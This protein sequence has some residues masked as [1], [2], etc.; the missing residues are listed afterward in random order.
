MMAASAIASAQGITVMIDGQAVNFRDAQ[1]RMMNGR[2]LV[3]LRGV[4]EQMGAYVHWTA[5]TETI[6]A[7]KGATSVRL[8]IGDRVANVNGQDV[9]LDVPARL[10]GGSTMVPLRFVSEALGAD[11]NWNEP[12][13]TVLITTNGAAANNNNDYTSWDNNNNNNRND[14]NWNN[15]NRNRNGNSNRRTSRETM[16]VA[17]PANTVIPVTLNTTLSSNQSR[18]GDT[19]TANVDTQGSNSYAGVPAGTIAEGHVVA[20]MPQNGQNPGTIQVAFDRLRMPDGR[21]AEID[22]T[23]ASMNSKDITRN[24]NGTIQAKGGNNKPLV[25][26]GYGAGAGAVIGMLTKGNILTDAAIGA[27]L[28]YLVNILQKDKNNPHDVLLNSGTEMGIRLN[29]SVTLP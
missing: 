14:R 2:V 15:R 7:T 20:A 26:V 1:P 8:R 13:E 11:V 9:N 27:G 23:L 6:D 19:F 24:E 17:L 12:Q 21:T 4:F 25:F 18:V 10:V 3:P 22:G 16:R 29:Q 5:A 28:G